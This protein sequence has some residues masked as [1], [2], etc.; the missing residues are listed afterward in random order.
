MSSIIKTG[1]K[2]RASM[3]DVGL[4]KGIG[5]CDCVIVKLYMV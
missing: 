1:R 2:E 4:V 5:A 3:F